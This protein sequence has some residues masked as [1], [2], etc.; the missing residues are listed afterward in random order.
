MG[1][2]EGRIDTTPPGIRAP[3]GRRHIRTSLER[4]REQPVASQSQG[5]RGRAGVWRAAVEVVVVVME[6]TMGVKLK[7]KG[8][9]C[10]SLMGN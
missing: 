9:L 6:E 2:W 8:R 1:G 10:D 7:K 5:R 4:R 3:A